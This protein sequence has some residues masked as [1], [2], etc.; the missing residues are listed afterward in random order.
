MRP[1]L[2]PGD[3]ALYL[4]WLYPEDAAAACQEQFC[5][6]PGT[7]TDVRH[8]GIRSQPILVPQQ[9]N[10]SGGIAR[11]VTKVILNSIGKSPG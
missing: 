10:Y 7:R 5:Q 8:G 4:I 9:L 6:F 11:A 1:K 3:R 2:T